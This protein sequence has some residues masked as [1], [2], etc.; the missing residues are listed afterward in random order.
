LQETIRPVPTTGVSYA[1][2]AQRL[3]DIARKLYINE[4]FDLGDDDERGLHDNS[5]GSF[6]ERHFSFCC[7]LS[8]RNE[9]D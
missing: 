2:F 6:R 8:P 4:P 7:S 1:D 3:I 9:A 5:G